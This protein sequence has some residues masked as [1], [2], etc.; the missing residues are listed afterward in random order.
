MIAPQK[1]YA[2][3][4]SQNLNLAIRS[5]GWFLSFRKFRVY[6]AEKYAVK[7]AYVFLGYLPGNTKLYNSLQQAGFICIFKPTLT[8]KDG[9]TKGNCDAELVLQAMIE[10]ENYD[11]AIIVSGDGDFYCLANYFIGKKKLAAMMVPNRWKFSGLL[12]Y[13]EIKPYLRFMNDL[14]SKLAHKKEKAPQGRNLEG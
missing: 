4:D 8:Y 14:E 6:L 12:K 10:Y 7:E 9:T 3:I 11:Q 2:L 5:L 1:N 13:P